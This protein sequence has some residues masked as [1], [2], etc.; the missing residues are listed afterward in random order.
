MSRNFDVVGATVAPE[1]LDDDPEV[2]EMMAVGRK[3]TIKTQW[4]AV[5]SLSHGQHRGSMSNAR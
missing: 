2:K 4:K 1:F 5:V 3:S